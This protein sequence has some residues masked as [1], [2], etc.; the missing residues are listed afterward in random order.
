MDG[1]YENSLF[2]PRHKNSLNDLKNFHKRF[3][4]VNSNFLS[5]RGDYNSAKTRSFAIKFE[6]CDSNNPDF[7][8][9]KC[10]SESEI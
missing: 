6:K 1:N 8:G 3:R 2:Y 4:C 7:V 9:I 10:K 5:I